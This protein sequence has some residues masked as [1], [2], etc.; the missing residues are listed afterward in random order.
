MYLIS[1]KTDLPKNYYLSDLEQA[2]IEMM[3]VIKNYIEC[4]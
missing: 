4:D 1:E 2:V 3:I